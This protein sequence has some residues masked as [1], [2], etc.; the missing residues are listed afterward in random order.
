MI[1]PKNLKDIL[2]AAVKPFVKA[3]IALLNCLTIFVPVSIFSKPKSKIS[4]LITFLPLVISETN[5]AYLLSASSLSA[6]FSIK[7]SLATVIASNKVSL[8][9]AVA[10]IAF[11]VLTWP[12]PNFWSTPIFVIPSLSVS[13]NPSIN[14]ATAFVESISN[15]SLKLWVDIP[16]TFANNSKFAPP[17]AIASDSS[18]ISL[19]IAVAPACDGWPIAL[20][21]VENANAST[22]VWFISPPICA[23]AV[24]ICKAAVTIS[25][26]VAAKLLPKATS[27]EAKLS[28]SVPAVPVI[29]WSLAIDKAAWSAPKLVAIVSFWIVSVNVTISLA[30]TPN[31]PPIAAISFIASVVIG[32]SFT[33]S[34]R[35]LEI[36]SKACSACFASP[37]TFK[38]FLTLTNC[39]SKAAAAAMLAPNAAT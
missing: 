5:V 36:L 14:K 31:W 16:A 17:I 8:A 13:F 19:T 20:R 11:C 15:K 29:S 37:A 3:N 9:F 38:V 23:V 33:I 7:A 39:S 10:K 32:A 24:A 27:E 6:L 25:D 34:L 21:V 1:P 12:R 26:S 2:S 30:A 35:R 22:A 28:N 18:V 4:P